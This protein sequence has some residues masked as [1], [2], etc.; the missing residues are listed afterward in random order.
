MKKVQ[1][2]SILELMVVIAITGI[3]AALATQSYEKFEARA[4]QSETK[5]LLANA[6]TAQLAHYT[7]FTYY[8]SC[9]GP[10]GALPADHEGGA[11]G[12]FY[13]FGFQSFKATM[14]VCGK[15]GFTSCSTYS[16]NQPCVLRDTLSIPK[17][18]KGLA[19]TELLF[20]GLTNTEIQKDFYRI[21]GAGSISPSLMWDIW[22]ITNEKKLTWDVSGI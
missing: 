15:D 2:F 12:G 6:Y 13:A 19:V 18:S 21:Q 3:L 5:L 22:S 16:D 17:Q 7:E 11:H 20:D 9:L 1:G 10:I 8:T 14:L 4:R